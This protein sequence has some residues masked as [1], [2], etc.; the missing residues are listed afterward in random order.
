MKILSADQIR[1]ADLYTIQEEPIDS[2]DLMERAARVFVNWFIDKT[3]PGGKK[4]MVLCGMGNNGGDGLAIARMLYR[5]HYDIK[6]AICRFSEDFSKDARTN[7]NRLP[8]ALE[9]KIIDIKEADDIPSFEGYIL[10]DAIFGTG[11][12]RAAE[13][14]ARQLIESVNQSGMPVYSV[15]LPSGLYADAPEEGEVINAIATISFELPKR[16]FY[17]AGSGH[18]AGKIEIK[19]IGLH[20][21]FLTKVSTPFA[22]IDMA[23]ARSV[24]KKRSPFSHKGNYGHV[25]LF[26]G[27]RGSMGAVVMTAMAAMRTGSGLVSVCVPGCGRDILQTTVPECM[28]IEDP[29][30][31]ILSALPDIKQFDAIGF[32]PGVGTDSKTANV[33]AGLSENMQ[34]PFVLDADG[35]N[36][37]SEHPAVKIHLN[38]QSI[39]TPHPKEFDRL[40]G[41]S[42]NAWERLACLES[43]V[44]D[45]G[46]HIV[47]KGHRTVIADLK[48]RTAFNTTG[49]PGMAT[50]GSGDVLTGILVSL[51][52]QGYEPAEAARLGVF[53]HG[54]AGDLAAIDMGEEALIATDIIRYLGKA[55]KTIHDQ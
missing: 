6:V 55:F 31:D 15:D 51:L 43:G 19:S 12:S 26:G 29:H 52:G 38:N 42:D 32:G 1:E 50:G 37:L 49:N 41:Q 53:L 7:Y 47:L 44:N 10:I 27:K 23:Y 8:Q 45:L 35:I 16:S 28:V 17:I 48:G 25:L 21:D 22:T 4:V 5:D 14:I 30:P 39:L 20:P 36:I 11:L 24:L 33:L 2:I 34:V 46:C 54:L 40:F 9:S 18:K 3:S 13:G